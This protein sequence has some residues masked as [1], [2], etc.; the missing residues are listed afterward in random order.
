MKTGPHGACLTAASFLAKRA[1]LPSAN[2]AGNPV[3]ELSH[4]GRSRWR[5]PQRERRKAGALERERAAAPY[6]R[7]LVGQCAFRRSA[8]FMCRGR[9]VEESRHRRSRL[10]R[11]LWSLSW[12]DAVSKARMHRIARTNFFSC[13]AKRGRGTIRSERR[14]RRMVEGASDS[15][16]PSTTLRVVPLPHRA[17]LRRG[18]R[19]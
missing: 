14:E 8:S 18:G 6:A 17:S 12:L 19:A 4:R 9:I 3:L 15:C 11:S 13:P 16:A 5:V 2:A 10:F 1:K 7:T